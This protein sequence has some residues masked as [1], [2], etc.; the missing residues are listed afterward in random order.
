MSDPTA[1]YTARASGLWTPVH[2]LEQDG[3]P[4][5][6]LTIERRPWGLIAGARWIPS[7]GEVLRIRRDPGL[8]RS[9]FSLWTESGEWLGSS[10][11]WNVLK[12]EV[13]LHTGSRPLRLL[14]G[15]GLGCGWVLVAPKTGAMA[16]VR[17]GLLGRE[18]R[19]E[20][21]RRLDFE[22]VVFTYFLGSMIWAESAWPGPSTEPVGGASPESPSPA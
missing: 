10:L 22:L 19:I 21:Y 1:S 20:V 15:P 3:E 9:Q 6:S 4:V 5:G 16:R 17:G 13:V 12:R 8:L 7:R 18:R 11:R 14:P 2:R